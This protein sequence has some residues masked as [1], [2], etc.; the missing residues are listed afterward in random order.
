MNVP[1]IVFG[2]LLA[3]I[4]ALIYHLIRGGGARRMAL[5]MVSAWISFFIGQAISILLRWELLRVGSINLFP[6]LLATLIGLVM[7]D[8]FAPKSGPRPPGKKKRFVRR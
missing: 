8:I 3:S 6:A 4:T 1:S 7:A 5:F 2:I